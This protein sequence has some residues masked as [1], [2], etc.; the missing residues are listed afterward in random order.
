MS[1]KVCN[2]KDHQGERELPLSAFHVDKTTKDGYKSMCAACARAKARKWRAE[3]A[4]DPEWRKKFND[5]NTAA[6]RKG[7]K[8]HQLFYAAM[9]RA[10]KKGIEFTITKDDVVIPEVCPILGIPIVAGTGRVSD[11][12]ANKLVGATD[13]SPS[14]DRIHNHLGYVSGNVIVISWKANYLKN[15]ATL[16]ELVLLGEFAK[17]QLSK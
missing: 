1:T 14:L 2:H 8:V 10:R 17:K 3:R 13:N 16:E 6:R 5:S 9:E 4:K 12:P 7:G 11:D 15:I